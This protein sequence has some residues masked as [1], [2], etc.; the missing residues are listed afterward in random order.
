MQLYIFGN[1][2]IAII[3]LRIIRIIAE[4]ELLKS[5]FNY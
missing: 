2:L 1:E 5:C 4:D 3:F